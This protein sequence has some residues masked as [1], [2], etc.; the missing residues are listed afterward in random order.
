MS[1]STAAARA[2]KPGRKPRTV[3]ARSV[4]LDR[5]KTSAD[6]PLFAGACGRWRKKVFG[7]VHYFGS[8]RDDP[9]GER[10]AQLWADQKDDLIAGRKPRVN[11][12]GLKL[13]DLADDFLLEKERSRDA[14]EIRRTTFD[15]Y[16]V[17]AKFVVAAFGKSRLV[18][19]LTAD[20]FRQLR[21]DLDKRYG[22]HALSRKI[23]CIRTLFKHGYDAGLLQAPVRFGP[24]FKKPAARIMRAHRQKSGPR[25]FEAAELRL[26]LDAAEPQ[27]KAMVL[28]AANCGFG[29]H[30]CGML[31]MSA[32]DL[33]RGWIRFPRPKTAVERR[34]P[35]W[36]ETIEAIQATLEVRPKPKH[37]EYR[38]RLFVTKYG[39]GWASDSPTS[40]VSHEFRKLLQRIDRQRTKQAAERG[41]NVPNKLYKAGRSFYAL[42]HGFETVAGGSRD[43]VA[44]DFLMGHADNSMSGIYR[45]RIEDERLVRVSEFVHRWLWPRPTTGGQ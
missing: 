19:D 34:C 25:M 27:M 42:R 2:K 12:D 31:P 13:V 36:S 1:H 43:Q 9:K 3:Q 35:L 41:E 8:W 30:D 39:G 38:E 40:P 33:K 24:S 44:V 10:A 6:F 28:L 37:V 23:Q 18:D 16:L 45:E 14:G 21:A 17:T 7:T 4:A 29:N 15:H 20:D 32:I 11:R 26:I 5:P 22:P